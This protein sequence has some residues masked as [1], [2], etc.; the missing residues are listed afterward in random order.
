MIK[1]INLKGNNIEYDLAIKP[2]KNIN[3]R[4]KADKSIYLSVNDK[5]SEETIADFL[6]SRADYILDAL[7]KYDE[8]LKYAKC[9]KQLVS[10]ESYK[11]FGHQRRLVIQ[12]DA[13]NYVVS[14]ESYIYLHCKDPN[15]KIGNQKLLNKWLENQLKTEINNICKK[16]YQKIEK[17]GILY[18]N[19]RYRYMISRWG[20]C[21]PKRC[22][23]TFNYALINVTI[24]A[25]EYVVMHEF[26][27]LLY[28]NHSKNYYLQL[29][30]FMPDW[31]ERKQLL[32]KE[33]LQVL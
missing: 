32:D 17:Y 15:D 27:H 26:T 29:T 6:Q 12:G 28:P 2:V 24:A 33:I 8:M 31:R 14:D 1:S 22:I 4:I 23:L 10:G 5:I 20:S 9:E 25:I 30:T 21:Q 3:L 19:L 18:P 7:K 16:T 11:V 13:K